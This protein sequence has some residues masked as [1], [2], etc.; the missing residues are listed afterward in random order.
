VEL[1]V[2]PVAMR[3]QCF[4]LH[5]VQSS[6]KKEHSLFSVKTDSGSI[7]VNLAMTPMHSVTVRMK[8]KQ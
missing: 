4:P 2:S 1:P 5:R 7:G 3:Q 8:S 6:D